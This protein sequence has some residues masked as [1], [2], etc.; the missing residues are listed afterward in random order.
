MYITVPPC[1][2]HELGDHGIRGLRILV[3]HL[4]ETVIATVHGMST[5]VLGVSG[6]HSILVH[7]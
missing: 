7:N 5:V 3:D 6:I 4:N 2:V 1:Q